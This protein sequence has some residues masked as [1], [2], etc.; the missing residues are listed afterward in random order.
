MTDS[1][2]GTPRPRGAARGWIAVGTA[3]A[4]GFGLV[5]ASAASLA[6]A[7]PLVDSTTESSV[8]PIS[9]ITREEAKGVGGAV[10]TV[11][12]AVGATPA[13]GP[14]PSPTS[15]PEVEQAPAPAPQP[16]A[17]ASAASPASIESPATVESPASVE[18]VDSA[19]SAD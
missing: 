17:P 13:D 16:V 8:P 18:S 7:M 19:D 4:L 15:A 2:T 5:A 12:A 9:S 6:G 10:A 14:T 1:P 11:G 3:S